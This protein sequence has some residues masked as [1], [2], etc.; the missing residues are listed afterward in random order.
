MVGPP[1]LSRVFLS[2]VFLCFAG[3]DHGIRIYIDSLTVIPMPSGGAL[4]GSLASQTI[5]SALNCRRGYFLF[6]IDPWCGLF[7]LVA[8]E[9][10]GNLAG[11]ICFLHVYDDF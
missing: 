7:L 1:V 4:G 11:F 3:C 10:L 9:H 8:D 6:R 2:I 5:L